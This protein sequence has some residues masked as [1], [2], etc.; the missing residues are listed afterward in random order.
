MRKSLDQF[1][2]ALALAAGLFVILLAG[3]LG[4]NEVHG[5]VSTLVNSRQVVRLHNELRRQPK[6]EALKQH[7]RQLD[8]QLRRETFY[9]LTLSHNASR[10]LLGGLV[11]FL[12]S[13]H[14]TRT[15][16]RKLPDPLAWGVRKPEQEN[17]GTRWAQLGVSTGIALVALAAV[18]ASPVRLPEPT[19]VEV[20]V[21]DE[22]YRQA[23]PAFRGSTGAGNAADANVSL[24]WTIRWKTPVPLSGMSSPVIWSN[25]VFLTGASETED[26]VFRFDAD[27]GKLL[28]SV[29][30]PGTKP[31][32]PKVTDDTGLAAPTTVTD[33]RRVYATSG[34]WKIPTVMRRRRPCTGTGC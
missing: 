14:W 27:T 31:P 26:R 19:P 4:F 29:V 15:R 25:S 32:A 23:W 9:R 10:A 13:A 7:I 30:V 11:I 1:A 3:L 22:E 5:K 24:P 2:F 8:L 17:R 6:D 12:L 16:R 28:W 18:L 34:R 21:S 33:G 20:P